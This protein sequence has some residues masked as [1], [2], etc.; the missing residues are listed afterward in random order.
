MV[1]WKQTTEWNKETCTTQATTLWAEHINK[2]RQMN[3]VV[4]TLFADMS[5]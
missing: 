3:I 2:R 5:W 4:A 1:L